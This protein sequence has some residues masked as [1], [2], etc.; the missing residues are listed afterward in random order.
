MPIASHGSTKKSE[1]IIGRGQEMA[2]YWRILEKQSLLLS[3]VRRMGKTCI[4]RKMCAHPPDGWIGI[5]YFVQGKTCPEEFVFDLHKLLKGRGLIKTTKLKDLGTWAEKNLGNKDFGSFKTPSFKGKWKE[6]LTDIIKEISGNDTKLVIMID[7]LPLMLWELMQK[8]KASAEAAME[9][10]DALRTLRE[11]YEAESYLRF[12]FCG[13]IG[14]GVVLQTFKNKFKYMGQPINNMRIEQ[15]L[16]MNDKDAAALCHY[17]LEDYNDEVDEQAL[18]QKICQLT[19]N[20]PY[21]IE[22]AFNYFEAQFIE[23]PNPDHAQRAFESALNNPNENHQFSHFSE[24]I[25]IYYS[26]KDQVVAYHILDTLSRKDDLTEEE[27]IIN[28]VL[29][30]TDK[31]DQRRIKDVLTRLWTDLCIDRV[32]EK[33]TR[34]Y[35]FKFDIIKRWWYINK[36]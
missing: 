14:M 33:D 6:L 25:D 22:M 2:L 31:Y 36:A 5:E 1:D 15:V 11:T 29:G 21:Y 19:N 4:L 32:H 20:I 26:K 24:R 13:S 35:Q 3:S 30:Q 9:L 23:T 16:Q 8:D 10:L 34:L 7:E 27:E 18:T 12:I 17:F 28:Y